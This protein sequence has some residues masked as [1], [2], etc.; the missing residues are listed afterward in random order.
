MWEIPF[1]FVFLDFTSTC[2]DSLFIIQK[3]KLLHVNTVVNMAI[4]AT[5]RGEGHIIITFLDDILVIGRTFELCQVTL[6]ETFRLFVKLGFVINFKKS[7]LFPCQVIEYLG[8]ILNTIQLTVTLPW[9]K[10]ERFRDYTNF[11][12]SRNHC[13]ICE[14][15]RLLDLMTSYTTAMRFGR[16]FTHHLDIQKIDALKEADGNYDG[17]MTLHVT[18]RDDVN[19][20]ITHLD[21]EF[22]YIKSPEPS[23]TLC[24]DAS[25]DG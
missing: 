23:V 19:W 6:W 12:L 2:G 18:S 5:L 10:I 11:I 13:K 22:A 14:V 8:Y 4:V 24:T 16:L 17:K 21:S 9:D 25:L 7:V 15:A 1:S 3:A 20:W